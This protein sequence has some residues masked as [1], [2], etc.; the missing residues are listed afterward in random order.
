MEMGLGLETALPTKRE[1][2]VEYY[3]SPLD[4]R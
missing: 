3:V 2:N 4:P 1:F